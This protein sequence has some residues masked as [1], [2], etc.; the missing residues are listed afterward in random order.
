MIS[1]KELRL[2]PEITKQRLL[3][4]NISVEFVDKILQIDEERVKCI[5]RSD[6]IKT[7]RNKYS[8]EI[9]QLIK[10]K[11]T[12]R[13]I[14]KKK[15]DVSEMKQEMVDLD[16]K[17]RYYDAEIKSLAS[18]IPAI[19]HD[20]VPIGVDETDNKVI[21]E[22]YVSSYYNNN[23]EK[24]YESSKLKEFNFEIKDY[25]TLGENLG[26]LD[27][28]GGRKLSGRGFVVLKDQGAQLERALINFMIDYHHTNN[29]IE[30]SVP[31]LVNQETMYG[32]GKLPK[33][34]FDMF[35]IG[36]EG[37]RGLFLIPTAEVPIVNLHRD[38]TIKLERPL[39]YVSVT[40]CFRQEIGG[41]GIDSK[42]LQRLHQFNKVELV[43]FC[44]EEDSYTELQ[45]MV[46]HVCKMLNSLEIHYRVIELCTGEL[47]F[48]A[49][50]CYDIEIWS[51]S[52][53]KWLEIS[54][55]SNC[56]DFQSRR[57][58]IKYS[59]VN[60]KKYAHI[61]NGSGVALPRL[62]A[63]LMEANQLEDGTIKVPGILQYY[64]HRDIITEGM[65]WD[66]LNK[67]QK[68]N[69]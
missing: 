36:E 52:E 31:T 18:E 5:Y 57:A 39:K 68:I 45:N 41:Y 19:P 25:I 47:G 37:G 63:G 14:D 24:V 23:N 29:F 6:E 9:S 7:L 43:T 40:N 12:E 49:S 22:G 55:I 61:L 60:E 16:N 26:I 42:G 4:R 48:A 35:Q 59:N 65:D 11:A 54:S 10:E 21:V 58:N 3:T 17:I 34:E 28:K 1:L 46:T 67:I 51:Y 20:S 30:V 8:K 33:F 44:K 56:T 32:A 38:E 53:K 62:I 13:E 69:K 66:W 15:M 2:N 50:K 64:M 27:F